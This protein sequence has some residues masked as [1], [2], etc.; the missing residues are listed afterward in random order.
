MLSDET[1]TCPSGTSYP[2]ETGENLSLPSACKPANP[3]HLL[4]QA[5]PSTN[6]LPKY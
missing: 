2:L 3:E 5:F 6:L 4:H 1:Q